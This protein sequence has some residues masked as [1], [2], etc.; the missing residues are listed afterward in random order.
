MPVD[1]SISIFGIDGIGGSY[2][3]M[4][5]DAKPWCEVL[6]CRYFCIQYKNLLRVIWFSPLN[7]L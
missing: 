5:N 6:A 3:L 1:S 2:E 7:C 4:D